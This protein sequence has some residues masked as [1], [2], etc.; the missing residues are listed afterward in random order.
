LSAAL[1][2]AMSGGSIA[3]APVG[4]AFTYQGNLSAGGQPANGLYD[5]Q[6]SLW[7]APTRGNSVAGPLSTNGVEVS[8]GL[9]TVW[10]D[11][12]AAVFGGQADWLQVAVRT[13]GS[14]DFTTLFPLQP[15]T[16]S[17][18]ALY[19]LEAGLSGTIIATNPANQFQGVFAGNGAG[20]T[21][22]S[23]T[24]GELA[25]QSVSVTNLTLD[26]S[27]RIACGDI[28]AYGIDR[29]GWTHTLEKLSTNGPLFVAVVGNGWAEDS[30]FGGFVTNLLAYKPLAGYASDV[31]Y[32]LPVYI[33]YTASS[34]LDTALYV[35]GDDTNWH[36]SYFVLTN[37]GSIS[38]PAQIVVSD[39]CGIDYLANPNGGAF[40][41]EI[42]TNGAWTYD[43]TNLDNTWTTVT[44][45]SAASPGWQGRTVW[46]TN[47]SPVQ[48]QVRVRATSPG[49]TP[50]VG[51]AQWNSTVTNGVVLCQ[52]SHQNSGNWWTYTDTNKV[53][54]IW[55]AW[56]PDLVLN[57]GGF[58]NSRAADL[59]GTLTLLRNGFAGADVV[60]VITH[61]VSS[62]PYDF[63]FERQFCF[64]NG[65][66]CFDGQAASIAAWG[67][68]D[69]GGALG[70][71]P[72]PAH[73]TAEG[74]AAF[75]QLLWS[76]MALTTDS[77]AGRLAMAGN[78]VTT[79]ISISG[80]ATLYITNG[81]IWKVTV[82]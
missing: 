12:G 32:E 67:G 68:Y 45:A 70:L 22:L 55:R 71:Y 14:G 59:V 47:T 9:F 10:L 18:F 62:T 26:N 63:G 53:F 51:H 58:D 6:F 25:I 28:D 73:L 17:P 50:I 2:F 30:D 60:D 65:I 38:A 44:N 8:R 76:W 74:Y 11:F 48:T 27:L 64:A 79:N 4:T 41:L 35:S 75:S 61:V 31:L 7:D 52:Y 16:A 81:Q 77:P 80:G 29:F 34:G 43:F 23:I 13:N 5:F 49:W 66:P 15:L 72:V 20:L 21:N 3:A 24:A 36:G 39:I 40:A 46:W 37:T 42:R 33:A 1:L 78:G 54:P 19:A 82:P 56:R 57:T 69:N